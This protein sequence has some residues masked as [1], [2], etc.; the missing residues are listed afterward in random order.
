VLRIYGLEEEVCK[1]EAEELRRAWR[2]EL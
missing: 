2:R 1:L